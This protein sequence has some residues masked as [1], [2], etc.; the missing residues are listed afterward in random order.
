MRMTGSDVDKR[1]GALVDDA[2]RQVCGD[3][4]G[5]PG[6]AGD[7]PAK[8]DSG[9]TLMPDSFPG[10]TILK[11][12]HRGGQG[13]VYQ[14]VQ[15]STRRKVAIK[16]MREG[17]FASRAD[18]ARFE[19]E[20]QVLGQLR[21]PHIVTIHDSGEAAGLPYFVMDYIRGQPLDV[22]MAGKA[23]SIGDTLALFAK[24]CDAV[25]AAHLRGVI[26][27]DIKPGNIR[28]DE[29]GEP[30]ILDFG[31]AKV[32][33]GDQAVSLM[34]VTGQFVGSLPW[35][36]PEQAEGRSSEIDIRTDVYSLGV[37]L[38]QMLTGRFP[39]DVVGS[40]RDV[41][42][43]ITTAEPLRPSTIRRQIDDELDTIVLKCLHK[44]PVRRYQS[45]GELARDIGHYLAGEPIE[46]KR[47]STIYVLRKHLRRYWIAIAVATAFV[48]FLAVAALVSMRLYLREQRA[49]VAESRQRVLADQQYEEI[50]RLA[51]LK[52]LAD[53][54]AEADELWP[55]HPENISAMRAWLTERAYPLRDNLVRHE[56]TLEALRAEGTETDHGWTFADDETQWQYDTL[57]G[58]IADLMSFVDPDPY[59]GTVASVQERLAFAE[60]IE[61]R[62]V[63]EPE[64]AA[65]WAEAIADIAK[66]EIYSGLQLEPQMGLLPLRRDRRS[67]LW[68]FWHIQ[69][70]EAPVENPDPDALNPWTLTGETGLVFVL[71]PGGTFWVGAQKEDP[72]GRNYYPEAHSSE[73]PVHEIMLDPF[74]ISKYE[75]TQGQWERLTGA[76]PSHY[77]RGWSWA[78]DP[79][80]EAPIQEN[81]RWDP[82]E[83]V[84]WNDCNRVL[85]RLGLT[86]P[87]EAQWEYAA[88]AGTESAWWTGSDKESIGAKRAG[89]L[90]DGWLKRRGGPKYEEYEEWLEDGFAVHAPVGSFAAN[91]FGLHDVIGNVCEWC[92]DLRGGYE[93]EA[94]PGT[95]ARRV[96]ESYARVIRGGS[97]YNTAFY[98]RS[99]ARYNMV[100]P[101]QR[102]HNLGVRPARRL[103]R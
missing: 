59:T 44:E 47:D 68:E 4:D 80:A 2:R 60:T 101:E 100:S 87:T 83:Q 42:E 91:G 88:R 62:S 89:N 79:P 56:A 72:E 103:D 3:G 9:P 36:S 53:A 102:I 99:A 71:L 8:T 40:M 31:L 18:K 1:H 29:Q 98:A 34:T 85:G 30:H 23:H 41:L 65:R 46:A 25:N 12:V 58:L 15:E 76:D 49:L 38:F 97:Y 22:H 52:R 77:G 11:E 74:F 81:T 6:P 70:G 78:G 66:L 35:S 5:A 43:R 16:V 57:A 86:F 50:I 84:S 92:Y 93:S 45:A 13:V 14:A 90:M 63:S 39:Y 33:P 54:R 73:G 69:T 7:E 82:V 51:D 67:G 17:P 75:M 95:G 48:V 10:Y 96:P 32:A 28:V 24:I 19:R 37:V 61:E 21:H 26:H 20:V 55:A 64:P 27:R 94:E